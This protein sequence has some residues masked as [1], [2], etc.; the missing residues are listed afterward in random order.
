M[1]PNSKI[2]DDVNIVV[3]PAVEDGKVVDFGFC[4][5][6]TVGYDRLFITFYEKDKSPYWWRSTQLPDL[7]VPPLDPC[8]NHISMMQFSADFWFYNV[9]FKITYSDFSLHGNVIYL[10]EIPG[11]YTMQ[12]T[13][14]GA[15]VSWFKLELY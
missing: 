9:T 15:N 5:D 13:K 1:V 10:V 3:V 6:P 4:P 8:D 12:F 11:G 14:P 7:S 2:D